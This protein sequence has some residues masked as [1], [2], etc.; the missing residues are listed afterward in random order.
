MDVSGLLDLA[1]WGAAV[2]LVELCQGEVSR[3]TLQVGGIGLGCRSL[4]RET[5]ILVA[6]L[7]ATQLTVTVRGRQT[8]FFWAMHKCLSFRSPNGGFE[9][10]RWNSVTASEHGKNTH[11]YG[12]FC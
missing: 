11:W 3:H 6:V 4:C 7:V 8:L 9:M 2:C 12:E 1:G 5:H 10:L